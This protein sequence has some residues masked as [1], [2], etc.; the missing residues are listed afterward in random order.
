MT[1]TLIPHI[2]NGYF[3]LKPIVYYFVLR[4]IHGDV[5][6]YPENDLDPEEEDELS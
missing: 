3:K 6:K 1:S 4:D 5:V 2:S